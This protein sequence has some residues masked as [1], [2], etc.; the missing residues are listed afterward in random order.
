MTHTHTL[1]LTSYS[2][3]SWVDMGFLWT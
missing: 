3:T 2:D 1:N